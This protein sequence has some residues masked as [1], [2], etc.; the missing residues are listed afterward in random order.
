M[1]CLRHP[2][3]GGVQRAELVFAVLA[4]AVVEP[5]LGNFTH[6]LAHQLDRLCEP[7]GHEE[8]R[9]HDGQYGDD[10]QH[11]HQAHRQARHL[12]EWPL[13][14][15]QRDTPDLLALKGDRRLKAKHRLTAGNIACDGQATLPIPER[16]R[17]RWFVRLAHPLGLVRSAHDAFAVG[18][19]DALKVAGL[20]DLLQG[21]VDRHPILRQRGHRVLRRDETRQCRA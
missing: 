14:Q 10:H 4:D 9:H 2:I 19:R 17:G 21:H 8:H 6:R 12:H 11:R 20:H 15:A 13:T 7:V 1:Q 18:H 3:E 5:A 16:F